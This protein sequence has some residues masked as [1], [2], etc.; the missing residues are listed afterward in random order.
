MPSTLTGLLIFV[1]LLLPGFVHYSERRRRI[2]LSQDSALLE[3]TNLV[4][5]S[6]VADG[7]AVSLFAI[8][9]WLRPSA[10]LDPREFLSDPGAFVVGHPGLALRTGIGLLA[11]ATATAWL[12][13]LQPGPLKRV[14]QWFAPTIVDSSAWYHVFEQRRDRQD[15][16]VRR[17]SAI[18]PWRRPMR[19]VNV[20]PKY[21]HVG[22]TLRGGG[23]VSGIVDWYS[24]ATEESDDRGLVLAPPLSRTSGGN[25]LDVDGVGRIVLAAR[26]IAVMEVTFVDDV[27][28]P[29]NEASSDT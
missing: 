2:P 20:D 26:D 5:V 4:A 12:L 27:S 15:G 18:V 19:N 14:S 10:L 23:Y 9:R 13:A 6:L 29:D 22:C 7:V 25:A 1:A 16:D 24:T 11:I 28:W 21:V 3:T 8:G 17:I